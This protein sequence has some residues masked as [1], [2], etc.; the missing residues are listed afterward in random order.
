[1]DNITAENIGKKARAFKHCEKLLATIDKNGQA[2]VKLNCTGV[3]FVVHKDDAIYL[4]IQATKFAL[5]DEI[6]SYELT[7]R[8]QRSIEQPVRRTAPAP[9]GASDT[10]Q[11]SNSPIKRRPLTP[12]EKA[13]ISASCRAAW[14]KRKS[15]TGKI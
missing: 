13:K 9:V 12:D 11:P 2:R 6:K 7:A 4:R 5:L 14:A 15:S 10:N 1:M 8:S 3:E